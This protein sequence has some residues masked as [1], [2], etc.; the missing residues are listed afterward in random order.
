[1]K[2]DI[3]PLENAISQIEESLAFA[4]SAEAKANPRLFLQ[5]R[6][7]AIK[8]YEF[9]YELSWKTIKRF[10]E[11]TGPSEAQTDVTNF[12]DLIRLG[13]E[14]GLVRDVNAWDDYRD[15][16]NTTAHA[17]ADNKAAKVFAI[18]PQFLGD[19][20]YLRDRLRE[21]LKAAP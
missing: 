5:F 2:L 13:M 20:I 3:S 21:K 7:A 19:A 8:A 18:I 9:T 10:I 12:K 11:V 6:A 1:M 15:R 14:H 4:N 17:Y 16:R